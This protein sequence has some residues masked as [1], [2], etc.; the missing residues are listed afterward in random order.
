MTAHLLL[1]LEAPLMAFGAVAVDQ[2]R[3]VQ[4]WPARSMLTGLF[5]NA[6]G[7]Q[8]QE[9]DRLERLQARLRWAAR[10]DREG[11]LLTDFQTAQLGKDDKGWTT[12]GKPEGR[13]GGAKT[14]ESPHLRWRDFRADASVLISIGLADAAEE[15]TLETLAESLR[16]P[17][18]PLFIGRKSCIPSQPL[19]EGWAEGDD[20]L[21]ALLA[22][23]ANGPASVFFA[24]DSGN[25]ALSS[26][27][28]QTSDERRF[29][30]DQH[31]GTQWVHELAP[32]S[33]VQAGALP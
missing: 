9:S 31:A 30:I 2:R 23:E 28:I 33:T 15:P 12:H 26:R 13:D 19:H 24:E 21:S 27:R 16:R 10:L 11:T 14:Y 18:R 5:A 1:R 17:F 25:T 20:A 7:W 3:P 6:L 32:G 22:L 8:R 4:R 29:A